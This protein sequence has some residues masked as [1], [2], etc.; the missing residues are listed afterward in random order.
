MLPLREQQQQL[1]YNFFMET[2][3][4]NVY[5]QYTY[6]YPHKHAYRKLEKPIDLN[7]VWER[8]DTSNLFAY[9]HIPF[10]EM[11]CG[12]CN[13]FTIANPKE[14]VD[15]YL[16]ALQREALEYK[17]SIP[18]IQFEEY[19]IGG[20]TPTFLEEDELAKML[21]IFKNDLG[22]N[23]QSKYGSIEASPKS[24]NKEK[25]HLIEEFGIDR[26]SMGVQSWIE[27]ETKLLGRPQSVNAVVRAVED[28]ASSKV[29]EF[30]LDLIYGIHSQTK[31]SWLYSI[32][33]TLEYS[34]T[35]IFL[36]P[37]Y[38]RAL[39]GLAKMQHSN[40]DNRL[41]LFRIGRDYLLENGYM[42]TSMRCFRR[43]DAPIIKNNYTS[44]KDGMIGIGAGA[45]SYTQNLHYS[46]N[47]AVS[48]KATKNIINEYSL[49]EEFTT[50]D[51]GF[52]LKEEEQ[53]IRFLVKSL[54]DGGCLN[55][56][57]FR[58]RFGKDISTINIIQRL[59]DFNWLEENEDYLQLNKSGMEM[60]DAIG[61]MLFSENVK[62]LMSEY[63]LT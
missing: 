19:A 28:I 27:E 32:D 21:S 56:E 36:Y 17:K 25:I 60:E 62:F 54:I 63:N 24:I 52:Y 5:E 42:Q 16:N 44:T 2:Q 23:T 49:K 39:T 8:E 59:F 38:T 15:R 58:T 11:R 31:E 55:K 45:R 40:E 37:L 35:E 4:L 53:L 57:A 46:S 34:P 26:I 13:L 30:N 3:Q 33:R 14:G 41:Y 9:V 20:G 47:Y 22:V 6:S 7:K 61:P 1:E 50:I 10:C 12:F 48:R 29:P 43:A 18:N 51:Y